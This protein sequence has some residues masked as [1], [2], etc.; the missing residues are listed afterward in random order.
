MARRPITR[1]LFLLILIATAALLTMSDHAQSFRWR[2]D[3]AGESAYALGPAITLIEPSTIEAR[4]RVRADR[5][6]PVLWLAGWATE[7]S[8][9]PDALA[10]VWRR[11]T[12]GWFPLWRLELTSRLDLLPANLI[13]RRDGELAVIELGEVRPQ[14][15]RDYRAVLSHDPATGVLSL[16]LE[17]AHDDA[18][19]YSAHLPLR[20][21]RGRLFPVAGWRAPS[22]PGPAANPS[23]SSKTALVA[24]ESV[25][26]TSTHQRVGL[27][28]SL[29]RSF[30][31]HLIELSP[32]DLGYRRKYD[33]EYIKGDPAGL[34]IQW[35]D[36]PVPGQVVVKATTPAVTPPR[37][38][39]AA[40]GP[41]ATAA[42]GDHV[43]LATLPWQASAAD[44]LFEPGSLPA[45]ESVLV[46]E[47]VDG[48][49]RAEI[50]R[51]TV[52]VLQ[53]KIRASYTIDGRDFDRGTI[54]GRVMLWP[55][56]GVAEDVELTVAARF[57]GPGSPAGS[58][59]G[60]LPGGEPEPGT[61]QE[62]ELVLVSRHFDRLDGLVTLPFEIAAPAEG[63]TLRFR[64]SL[65]PVDVYLAG[66]E[67]EVRV[68]GYAQTADGPD[69]ASPLFPFVVNPWRESPGN[70]TDLSAWLDKPAGRHGFVAVEHGHFVTGDGQPIRFLGVNCA[71]SGCF[72]DHASAEKLARQLARFGINLVRFHHMDMRE[73][74]DGIWRRGVFPR[75][76]D[77]GQLDRLDYFIYQLKENGIY[78]NINLHVSRTLTPQEGY[79]D[80]ERRP[81]FD[82]GLSYFDRGIIEQQKAYARE[83][84]THLNPYT[85]NRYV[86]EPAVAMIEITNENGLILFTQWGAIDALPQRYLEQLD[87]RWQEWLA[88][89]YGSTGALAQAWG[90]ASLRVQRE[91][92]VNGRLERGLVLW[93][94][95][96]D[97]SARAHTRAVPG[98]GPLPEEAEAPALT[99]LEVNVIDKGPVSWRPQLYH[100]ALGL[101]PGKTYRVSFWIKADRSRSLTTNVMMHHD[102]WVSFGAREITATPQ[103]QRVEYTVR[104]PETAAVSQGRVSF[105]DL[106]AGATYWIAALS[107][108]Q[109]EGSGIGLPEGE[110]LESGV[111]RPP[112]H[113]L[114]TRSDQVR[115]DYIEFLWEIERAYFDEM[116]RYIKEELGARALVSGT[117]VQWSPPGIQ[118]ALDYVDAHAYWNHPEFPAGEW[119]AFEWFVR[120]TS[121][122]TSGDGGAITSLA[123][124]R[125]AGKPY[126]VSEYN[127]PAPNTFGSEAFLLAGAYGAFQGWDGLVAFAWSHDGDF[128]PQ[129]IP[130]LFDIKAHPTKLVTLPAVAALFVRGDVRVG[131]TPVYAVVDDEAQMERLL[132]TT[133]FGVG[134]AAGG[135]PPIVALQRRLA[136]LLDEEAPEGGGTAGHDV[137]EEQKRP[138]GPGGLFAARALSPGAVESDTGELRWIRSGDGR[139]VVLVDAKR[140]KAVIGY[141]GA[142]HAEPRFDLSGVVIAPGPT[143]Q[144]GWSAITLTAID[145]AGFAD[146]GRI[147][148]TATG[149]VEN[150]G[151]AWERLED[152]R[153]TVRNR[154]GEA[155]SLV[156]G[157]A[158]RIELPVAA[159]RVRVYALDGAGDRR[160]QVP[161]HPAGQAG[162]DNPDRESDRN[163][164]A[165]RA[166]FEIGPQYRTLWYEIEIAP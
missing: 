127:H 41:D 166:V 99:A 68:Q 79:P 37:P 139:G 32:E 98:A 77:P 108:Q 66:G 112:W 39:S 83:L 76:L 113:S 2:H 107:V 48:D 128:W 65:W 25:T 19:L 130:S 117:Q 52:R 81:E 156:E 110:S 120:N 59:T 106:E 141:R 5:G 161:V 49:H 33:V 35:P 116:Y 122:T 29:K 72:P 69:Q 136:L 163:G 58:G 60:P 146:P 84:L 18:V 90:G 154:W 27:P 115:R 14:P 42:E 50:Q 43:V 10:L 87:R 82:K 78:S 155:P 95:E 148:L 134:S 142:S 86:D 92:A 101:E 34:R 57:T 125:V 1:P 73:A 21:H 74:P 30:S 54:I 133:V 47:Y 67:R 111:T 80:P 12:D 135:V 137:E 131:E 16:L 6:E 123:H 56:V 13:D 140:S 53:A 23:A 22:G 158:A 150:T 145:G 45:G 114:G 11:A 64:A 93:T 3:P 138:M 162:A 89:R 36:E 152:D 121:M 28:L 31:S 61:E 4:F 20:P 38:G 164:G 8:A 17:D 129:R 75:Q 144:D 149:Y 70:V 9:P 109:L 97:E 104:V 94:L 143:L 147:L 132:E 118:A 15:G 157:I 124:T 160:E 63:G 165:D 44:V 51:H 40:S 88:A 85:G 55:E 119:D 24:F 103:W 105:T 151:M 159:G 46:L 62:P 102:P 91:L 96:T 153:V 71:F 126:V 7:R 26:V 100:T